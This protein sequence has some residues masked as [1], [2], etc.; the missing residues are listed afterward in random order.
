VRFGFY[1]EAEQKMIYATKQKTVFTVNA[2]IK[3]AN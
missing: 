2:Q 1:V 3:L